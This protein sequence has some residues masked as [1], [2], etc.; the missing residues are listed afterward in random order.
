MH[1]VYI[2]MYA[3]AQGK[4]LGR[5]HPVAAR[6]RFD[7]IHEQDALWSST[8]FIMSPPKIEPLLASAGSLTRRS[9]RPMLRLP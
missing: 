9:R 1:G 4:L 7:K 2:C 5:V 3:F 8:P 6:E